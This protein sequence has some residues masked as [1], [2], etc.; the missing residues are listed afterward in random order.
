M[1]IFEKNKILK[2]LI[3]GQGLAGSVLGLTLLKRG[4]EILVVDQN[5]AITSSKVA[6]GLFNPITG[7]NRSK[8]WKAEE[9]FPFLKRFYNELQQLIGGTFY[10]ELPIYMP[11]TTLESQNEWV[12]KSVEPY[13][14]QWMQIC[15]NPTDANFSTYVK[16]PYGGM[17]TLQSG[18]VD[19]QILLER[20]AEYL[21]SINALKISKFELKDIEW[22]ERIVYQGESFDKLIFCNGLLAAKDPLFSW[23]NHAHVKGDLFELQIPDMP[24]THIINKNGFILPLPNGNFRMGST[25]NNFFEDP[26]SITS[27]G[28]N[29]LHQKLEGILDTKFN[30]VKHYTATRPATKD[31]RPLL[32]VHP[33]YK[34]VCIFNG[35]GTKGVS[36]APY[37]AEH[38]AM[39]LE[40]TIPLF[41]E[42]NI[43]RCLKYYKSEHQNV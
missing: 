40:G 29:E 43:E 8:T 28:F 20:A 12:A 34:Q 3:I 2:F 13:W 30:I 5:E 22:Q 39:H 11:F 27:E 42:V 18:W 38:L 24:D 17:E 41:E 33:K 19:T 7:M 36:L 35:L 1:C 25:Y 37:L 6:A 23:L 9:L 14:A 15:D 21:Q 4:H 10:K 16:N 32:G 26:V 31:R